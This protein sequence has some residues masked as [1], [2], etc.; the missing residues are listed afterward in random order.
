L[1]DRIQLQQVFVNLMLN[2]IDAMKE[3]GG[4]MKITAEST[5]ED[6]LIVAVSDTGIGLP[7]D[8]PDD[9]FESFITT[10]TDGTGMGLAITRSIIEA[11]GG[12]LWASANS[13][14]GATFHFTLPND[15]AS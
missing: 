4:E 10:K 15:S 14:R 1:A 3:S 7:T 6:Q 9:I 8:N 2:A 11:H 5:P 13:E 12:R